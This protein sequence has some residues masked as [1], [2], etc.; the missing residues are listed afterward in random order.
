MDDPEFQLRT[1]QVLTVADDN[2]HLTYFYASEGMVT[3]PEKM[4]TMPDA[5]VGID[6]S[7]TLLNELQ[8]NCKCPRCK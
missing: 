1:M 5:E 3:A 4:I 2:T 8:K 7:S 6:I